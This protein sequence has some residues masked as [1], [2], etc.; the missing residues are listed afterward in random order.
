MLIAMSN[1]FRSHGMALFK[2]NLP[3]H[4]YIVIGFHGNHVIKK[5]I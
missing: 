2:E 4:N 5:H 3:T 1:Y